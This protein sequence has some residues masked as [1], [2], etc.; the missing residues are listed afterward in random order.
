MWL[1]LCQHDN[2][3]SDPSSSEHDYLSIPVFH[4]LTLAR[5]I[6]AST[7]RFSSSDNSDRSGPQEESTLSWVA[8]ATSSAESRQCQKAKA[9]WAMQLK[10]LHFNKQGRFRLTMV[11][12]WGQVKAWRNGVGCCH[13]ENTFEKVFP[14][15]AEKWNGCSTS[16]PGP[17][18]CLP[19][20][21]LTGH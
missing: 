15:L 10:T 20:I 5:C 9:R 14:Y 8:M 6:T 21:T 13:N 19:R 4:C 3:H 1:L 11:G 17:G 7:C 12:A 2:S 16:R 18:S